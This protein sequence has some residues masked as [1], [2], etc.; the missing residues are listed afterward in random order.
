MDDLFDLG[1][2]N[3]N[4]TGSYLAAAASTPDG[5]KQQGTDVPDP[6]IWGGQ[7]DGLPFEEKVVR[8]LGAFEVSTGKFNSHFC[9]Q[10]IAHENV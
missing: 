7:P 2:G 1:G 10:N 3:N 5:G 6:S 4:N 9:S 8:L